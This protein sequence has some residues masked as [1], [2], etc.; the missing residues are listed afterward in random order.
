MLRLRSPGTSAVGGVFTEGRGLIAGLAV[1]ELIEETPP[2]A[3]T[4]FRLLS[5]TENCESAIERGSTL[6]KFLKL[7]SM[8]KE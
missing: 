6:R 7:P 1:L 2:I 8:A 5:A 4:N 3:M